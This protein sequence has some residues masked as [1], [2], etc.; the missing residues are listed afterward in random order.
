MLGLRTALELTQ[1]GLADQLGVSRR[2]VGRW[3][4]GSD[5]PKVKHLKQLIVLAVAHQVWPAASAAEKIREMWHTAHQRAPLDETWLATL[6]REAPSSLAAVSHPEGERTMQQREALLPPSASV[7]PARASGG[8]RVD[9][10]NALAA[11][12]FYG[13][14]EELATLRH[15]LVE[16]RCRVVSVLGMGGIGK[17]ALVTTAGQQVVAHFEVV[18]FRSLRDAPSCAALLDDCLQVLAPDTLVAALPS[19]EARISR[20]LEH[21]R[22]RRVLLVLDNVETLLVEGDLLGHMRSGLE[23]YSLLLQRVGETAHASCLVLT[24]REQLT[25]LRSLEG[26]QGPVRAL[27]LAGLDVTAGAQLLA[28]HEL[29]GSVEEQTRLVEA[30]VGNPL[31]L[32]IVAQTIVELFG[33]AIGPFLAQGVVVFGSIAEQIGGQVA[34]LSAL[35]QTVLSWLA[36]VREPVTLAELGSLLAPPPPPRPLLEAVDSLRRRCLVERG[37]RPGSFTLQTVVLEYLTDD[38]VAEAVSEIQRGKLVR[39]LAHR[40]R[41][42]QAKDYVQQT[43]ERLIVTPI[44]SHLHNAYREQAALEERLLELFDQLRGEAD[45]VQGYGPANLLTL[46]RA[47]RGDLSQLDLSR[48]SLR[49]ANLQGV[50]MQD[51]SLAQASLYGCTFTETFGLIWSLAISRQGTYWAAGDRQGQVRVWRNAGQTLHRAW[52]A[53]NH[54]IVTIAISPDERYLATA[55]WEGGL[56]VWDLARG[57]SIWTTC[58]IHPVWVLAFAPDGRTLVS[59]GLDGQIH[60]WDVA[61]GGVLQTLVD[62]SG[63][64]F[65]LAWSRD[66]RWLAS[67]GFDAQIRLWANAEEPAS[68]LQLTP[69]Q[70]LSGHTS[71]VT[72]LA[73]APDGQTL[74][75]AAWDLTVKLWAIHTGRVIETIPFPT[76]HSDLAWSPD[77]RLLAAGALDPTL[78]VWDLEEHSQRTEFDE[79]TTAVHSLAFTPDSHTLVTAHEDGALRVW[80]APSG[81]CIRTTQCFAVSVAD[82]AWHPAGAQIASVGSTLTVDIWDTTSSLPLK[83]LPGH[84][85]YIWGVAWSPDG[86]QMASCGEDGTVRIWDAA[87]GASVDVLQNTMQERDLYF[88]LAWSPDGRWL[89]VGSYRQGVLIWDRITQTLRRV[90]ETNLPVGMRN[91]QWS[92]DG[93][94]LAAPGSG[95]DLCLWDTATWSVRTTLPGHPGRVTSLA[96]SPD[97]ARLATGTAGR[98]SDQLFIW[99]VTSGQRLRVLDDPNEFVYGVAWGADGE[100]LVSAGSDGVLRWWETHSGRC[101]MALQGHEGPVSALRTSPDRRLL[102]SCGDD[103]AIHLWDFACGQ[104]LKTL[105]RDRPYERLNIT[106]VKGLTETQKL[107]LR[108]MGAFEATT[109]IGVTAHRLPEPETIAPLMMG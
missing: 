106:G 84:H 69:F 10:G 93:A 9:W 25:V 30:Y 11:P 90:R 31:A 55:S 7:R 86:R 83:H 105:R 24:S 23:E 74:A 37:P 94:C 66:G 65:R 19:L 95:G 27:R 99:N 62:H 17:S 88:S 76:R 81:R 42:A 2:A 103:G 108:M 45:D 104:H 43:Q 39:L 91:L 20:L 75:S 3:E 5:Y 14:A 63:P 92:P 100:R 53:H 101:I 51:T 16:E 54:T 47:S 32:Q 41:Q 49:E 109:P 68:R 79:Q 38:L 29:V 107:S 67:A 1:A 6:L 50:T 61:T 72:G 102:A 13:R 98:G 22:E 36:V 48:L 70:R 96:W 35:E 64:V 77:G 33:G 71:M 97:G 78:W 44:V 26:S 18:I 8:V 73:F 60:L 40:L 57:F 85:L 28:T 87:T 82:L 58:L 56:T 4:G 59:A 12:T 80:D 46:L 21:L 52:Q 15:W 89:A 34:R